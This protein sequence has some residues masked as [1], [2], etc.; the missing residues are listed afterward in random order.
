MTDEYLKALEQKLTGDIDKDFMFLISEAN[1]LRK[2]G[3]IEDA[4]QVLK[5]FESKFA[6][7]GKKY[8]MNK[9]KASYEKRKADYMEMIECEKNN[10]IS[11][12]TDILVRLI[13]TFPIKR[14]LQEN[15]VLK[16]FN[17]LFENIHYE[18]F[19]NP[20]KKK[21]V[22]LEE[23]YANYYF[24][25]A[26]CMA[27]VEDYD[28][29]MDSLNTCL[30]YDEVNPDAYFLKASCY[31]KTGNIDEFFKNISKGMEVSYS[32]FHLG[33]AYF[34]LARYFSS[35]GDKKTAQVCILMA[36]NY[37]STKDL[38]E[39][40]KEVNKLPGENFKAQNIN[41]IKDTLDSKQIQLGPNPKVL[42][43]LTTAL[44]KSKEKG[45]KKLI[46]YFLTIL[47]ELTHDQ[48]VKKDLDDLNSEENNER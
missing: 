43:T 6:E 38:E 14:Q 2:L 30:S 3:L 47:F 31:Y 23:P 41:D 36:K 17:C 7:E 21:I 11:K 26:F 15:Q 27:Q 9:A 8:L 13:D 16:S 1:H 32:K 24:H 39:V 37:A 46:K 5:L 33:N 4:Q 45:N 29:A 12:A 40:E 18:N 22:L 42:Q 34:Q 44:K 10:D 48:K 28:K 35:I 20:E 25:L 19:Y